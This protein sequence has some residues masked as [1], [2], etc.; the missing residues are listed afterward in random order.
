[1]IVAAQMEEAVQDQDLDFFGGRM[2]KGAGI[3]YSD[4]GGNGNVSGKVFLNLR[5]GGK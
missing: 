1:M 3:L 4:L 5:I 2:L